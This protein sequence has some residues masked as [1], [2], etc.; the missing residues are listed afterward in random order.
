MPGPVKTPGDSGSVDSGAN[1]AAASAI[2]EL[3]RLS[4][5]VKRPD[6]LIEKN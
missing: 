5:S 2:P 1:Q 3:R 6:R 4:K